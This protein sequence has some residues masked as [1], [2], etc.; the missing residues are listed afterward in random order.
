MARS[1]AAQLAGQ[2]DRVD[3]VTATA[4][5]ASVPFAAFNRLIEVP[6]RGK[7]A[8]VLRSAREALGDGRLIIVDDAHLLDRLSA[9]LVHQ[10]A[11]SG[12]VNLRS[13]WVASTS[14]PP[15]RMKMKEGRKVNQVTSV[16]ATAPPSNRA[17]GPQTCLT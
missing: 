6:D 1:A 16:A 2:V 3:W 9:A 4:S 17:S 11:V 14:G 5:R 13:S 8:D 15:A 7:T 12:A 10:L